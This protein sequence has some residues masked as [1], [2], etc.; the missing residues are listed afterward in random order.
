[1]KV[2]IEIDTKT[3]IRFWLVVIGFILLGFAVWQAKD[4]LV[5]VIISAFLAL[6]LNGPVSKITKILPGS[7]K[8]RVGATAVSYFLI[9]VILSL[10]ASFVVPII[11]QQSSKFASEAPKIFAEITAENS[12]LRKFVEENNLNNLVYQA[13]RSISDMADNFSKN[14]GNILFGSLNAI[15]NWIFSL[16]MILTMTFL[17][18]VE[19]PS[20]IEK[21]WKLYTNHEKQK[22]HKKIAKR[23]YLAV[24]NYVNGQVTISAISGV[25]GA[26]VAVVLSLMSGI[27]M[28]LAIPI[29]S[30][31]F[32]LGM[33]PMFGATIAG[34]ISAMIIGFNSLWAGIIFLIYFVIYQQIENNIIS[35]MIQAKNN[36][37][38][39]LI[40][41]L[42]ITIGIYVLGL[43]GA[44][45]SIPV[46]ACLKILFEEYY[47][48][49]RKK[50]MQD[51]EKILS[52]LISKM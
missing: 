50:K 27:P 12:S 34:I 8:N 48:A 37:L 6:A 2:R 46:A 36:Q 32:V 7:K 21:I 19:G 40:I 49:S 25:L 18:L 15:A 41:I 10:V 22:R 29:G 42:A 1:M 24:A 31:L 52:E 3:F 30:I 51:D 23:M 39:A 44:L 33:I 28:G 11:A 47:L 14:L 38:S 9:V 17:M 43:L 13:S 45:I 5:L 16:F 20:W 4:A 35:P 26:F